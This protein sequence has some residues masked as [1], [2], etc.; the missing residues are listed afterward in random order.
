MMTFA[1][2]GLQVWMPTFL[3]R[4]HQLRLDEANTIFGG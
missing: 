4:M 2:G 1:I 3:V